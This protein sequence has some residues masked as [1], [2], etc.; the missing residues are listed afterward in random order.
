[1][2]TAVV[3]IGAPSLFTRLIFG[4]DL[5]STGQA[6]GRLAG[7]ALLALAVACWPA[8]SDGPSAVRALTAFALFSALS[9]VYLVFVGVRGAEV[10]ILLWPAVAVHAILACF[11]A[12]AWRRPMNAST[13]A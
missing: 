10:G 1:M 9:A 5:S 12:W 11:L 3:L 8:R 2:V 7:F 4:G 13:R 6:L